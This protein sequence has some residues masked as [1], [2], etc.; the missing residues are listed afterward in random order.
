MKKYLK[1]N[2]KDSDDPLNP[3]RQ[4]FYV[5]KYQ[6]T[7]E[8]ELHLSRPEEIAI[9][10]IRSGHC[11]LNHV[12]NRFDQKVSPFCPRCLEQHEQVHEIIEHVLMICSSLNTYCKD[13]RQKILARP[14]FEGGSIKKFIVSSN[15][16]D[17]DL[18]LNLVESL[19]KNNIHF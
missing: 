14:S 18:L 7:P 9:A 16:G 19:L 10:R 4:P 3:E 2:L 17:F 11:M 13:I 8:H 15:P 6:N 1:E 12:I 5:K